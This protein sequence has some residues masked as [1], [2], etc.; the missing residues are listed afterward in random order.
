MPVTGFFLSAFRAIAQ[1]FEA[2]FGGAREAARQ[3]G[4]ARSTFD[5]ILTGKTLRPSEG[6][7]ERLASALGGLEQ[8]TRFQVLG[9]ADI[10]SSEDPHG[11]QQ[12]RLQFRA[13]REAY[14]DSREEALRGW[15]DENARRREAGE[16][17]LRGLY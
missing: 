11:Q 16:A 17:P 15:K 1:A 2:E 10:F 6:T 3:T 4:I 13:D 5:D 7:L 8:Q 14:Q 9:A 12:L